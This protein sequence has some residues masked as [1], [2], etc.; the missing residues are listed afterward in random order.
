VVRREERREVVRGR[1]G[2]RVERG[3]KRERERQ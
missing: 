1:R 2:G 3:R